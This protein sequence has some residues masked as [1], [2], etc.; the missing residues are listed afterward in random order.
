MANVTMDIN[1]IRR[2]NMRRLAADYKNRRAFADALGRSEQQLY[3][4]IGKN[5]TKSIGNRIA[6]DVEQK[7]TLKEYSLD[8]S[9]E[10]AENQPSITPDGIDLELLES[11]IEAV[12]SAIESQGLQGMPAGKKAQAVAVAYSAALASSKNQVAPVNFIVRTLSR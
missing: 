2:A 9:M 12:E 3:Q 6:R 8:V 4:L 1:E 5:A 11:C 10:P 7:L